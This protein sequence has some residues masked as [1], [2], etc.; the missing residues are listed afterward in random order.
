MLIESVW[1]QAGGYPWTYRLIIRTPK[2]RIPESSNEPTRDSTAI[3]APVSASIISVGPEM[4]PPGRCR[5]DPACVRDVG[6]TIKGR[7]WMVWTEKTIIIPLISA[8]RRWFI[9]AVSVCNEN[10]W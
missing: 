3:H 10:E 8:T 1:L 9:F 5:M 7:A 4:V 6:S 2:S